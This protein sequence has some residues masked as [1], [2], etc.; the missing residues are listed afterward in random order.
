[1]KT[2]LVDEEPR[3]D[4]QSLTAPNSTFLARKFY[5]NLGLQVGFFESFL[6]FSFEREK[7]GSERMKS[8]D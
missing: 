5:R 3:G 4:F 1:M 8:N 6:G 2:K 7:R